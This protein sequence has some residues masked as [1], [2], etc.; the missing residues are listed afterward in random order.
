MILQACRNEQ[1]LL[2][3]KEEI[4]L[5]DKEVIYHTKRSE[6]IDEINMVSGS[7]KSV[8]S[9]YLLN[10]EVQEVVFGENNVLT[11]KEDEIFMDI[12]KK[13]IKDG[14]I[15]QDEGVAEEG[16]LDSNVAMDDFRVNETDGT[17]FEDFSTALKGDP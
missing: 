10:N 1:S 8:V 16:V 9:E 14:L 7:E 2:K 5:D 13:D 6:L 4:T 12:A 3:T 17:A 11:G 15:N